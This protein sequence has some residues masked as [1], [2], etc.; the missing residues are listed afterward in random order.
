MDNG[1]YALE[2]E[3]YVLKRD[4][5]LSLFEQAEMTYEE[6]Q[7]WLRLLKEDREAQKN[8]S[9]SVPSMPSMP[10]MPSIPSIPSIPR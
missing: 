4:C 7:E 3:R 1:W 2:K 10:S 6:R 8:G 9:S 5:G